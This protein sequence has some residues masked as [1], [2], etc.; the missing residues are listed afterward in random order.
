L[1][2]RSLADWEKEHVAGAYS[3]ELGKCTYKHI[4]QRMLYMIS[5]ID[6]ELAEK[7][8]KNLGMEVPDSVDD[9]I[10]QAIGAD[11]EVEKYQ[12]R[13]KENYL[14]ASKALSQAHTKF[15]SIATRQ[16]AVLVADGFD[17]D[18]FEKMQ[19]ALEEKG[20]FVNLIA[21]HGGSIKCSRDMEHEVDAS[22]STTESV[23]FD[24]IFIPGG[25]DSIEALLKEKKFIKFIN[26]AFKH[27]KAIAFDGEAEKLIEETAVQD[28]L[29][30][31]AVH[32]D[33]KPENFINSMA[34]HRN[35]ARE[36]QISVAV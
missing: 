31:E 3:F 14:D 12:P 25:K 24:A 34:K 20:A 35:W 1:F 33:E 22:I 13:K 18:G 16:V 27:C 6:E 23:L 30:D 2:Y 8:G 17:M 21:P 29:D 9:P 36:M 5:Q 11:A 19:S 7:V 32:Q 28:Y 15:E 4:K 26:E 10:N